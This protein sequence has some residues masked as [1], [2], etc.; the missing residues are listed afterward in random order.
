MEVVQEP[1]REVEQRVLFTGQ[2]PS[3]ALARR[4]ANRGSCCRGSG[5]MAP[6]SK[7]AEPEVSNR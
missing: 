3:S 2:M 1:I 4:H 6:A 5:T 7:M